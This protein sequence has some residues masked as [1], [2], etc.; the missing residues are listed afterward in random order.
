M[1]GGWVPKPGTNMVFLVGFHRYK[2]LP[3]CLGLVSS[4]EDLEDGD[5]LVGDITGIPIGGGV[6]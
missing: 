3:I 1:G 2:P 5:T 4:G 6:Q